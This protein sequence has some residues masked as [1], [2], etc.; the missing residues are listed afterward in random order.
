MRFVPV[1]DYRRLGTADLRF[2]KSIGN[3]RYRR[4]ELWDLDR[5]APR[6]G[7]AR[8]FPKRSQ[9]GEGRV[10]SCDR[11]GPGD[12]ALPEADVGVAH[13]RGQTGM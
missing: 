5:M 7:S 6:S 2:D 12:A 11:I 1:P 8:L 10:N 4:F 13:Q 3:H 9:D